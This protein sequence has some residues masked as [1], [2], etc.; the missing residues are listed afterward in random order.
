[1]TQFDQVF[2][3]NIKINKILK[4]NTYTHQIKFSKFS[5]ILLYQD[6]SKTNDN[7]DNNDRKI[8]LVD[9][10]DWVNGVRKLREENLF[11]P[12]TIMKIGHKNYIFVINTVFYDDNKNSKYKMIFN[13]SVKS[14]IQNNT[15]KT[16][17]HLPINK[18]YKNVRFDVDGVCIP[19]IGLTACPPNNNPPCAICYCDM[20]FYYAN[21]CCDEC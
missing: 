4:K 10:K 16:L 1:M 20:G 8:K 15:T 6:W 3:G 7:N 19:S 13:V 9:A 17:I 21:V 5:K 18:K 12:T 2:S 11:T 14:I